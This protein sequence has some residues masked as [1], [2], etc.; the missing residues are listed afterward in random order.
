[1]GPPPEAVTQTA[2]WPQ[3]KGQHCVH[4]GKE[5]LPRC[6]HS[7]TMSKV[8]GQ[9]GKS[10]S[11]GPPGHV[12]EL[13]PF[14]GIIAGLSRRW[15][16]GWGQRAAGAVKALRG[17]LHTVKRW[18]EQ[19]AKDYRHTR[20]VESWRSTSKASVLNSIR[21]FEGF[22][23]VLQLLLLPGKVWD[24]RREYPTASPLPCP[25]VAPVHLD[26]RPNSPCALWEGK[27]RSHTA[28][29]AAC[30]SGAGAGGPRGPGVSRISVS[31]LREM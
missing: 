14:I 20:A 17:A 30:G 8:G 3:Y 11:F 13:E 9:P 19:A 26:P 22:A 18:E 1:M 25:P 27:L 28:A 31:R 5:A 29:G 7:D 24:Q 2:L 10:S 15:N 6:H 23:G 21:E 4:V 12:S 16:W